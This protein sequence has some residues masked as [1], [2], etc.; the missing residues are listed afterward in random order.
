MAIVYPFVEAKHY[1]KG[2]NG[3]KPRL[4]VIH[5]M[6]T[7]EN[8]GRAH[9]VAVWFSGANAPQASA[10]YMVDNEDI[11]QTVHEEDT[12]WAVD[13]WDLNQASISVE[14][15]GSASQT[16]AQWTDAYSKA[17]LAL[18]ARLT[19]D[20]AHRWGIPA[21]KLSPADIL[22]G[23]AGFCGHN[24]ITVAKKIAGGH[25][26]PGR[27]FPWTSYLAQVNAILAP[28]VTAVTKP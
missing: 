20:I 12:A 24:D 1:T 18:S 27:S 5:T 8:F 15:A 13:D 4:I 23:K 17:E 14:H 21:V 6:E 22:A 10:H 11:Y 7:P 3:I 28:K 2:R 26:D 25:Q 19:A 16:A 9:Q